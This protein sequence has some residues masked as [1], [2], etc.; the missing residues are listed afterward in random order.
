MNKRIFL[1]LI[2]FLLTGCYDH[3]ELNKIAILTATEINKVNDEYI[4]KAEVVNPQSAEKST[5][6][7]APFIIYTGKGKTIQEAYRQIKLQSSRY[8]YSDHLQIVIINEQI[9]KEDISEII[10]F[11]MRSPAA[12]TEFNVL[13]GADKDIL[14]ITTPIDELSSTSILESLK[15]NHKYLGVSN[16]VTFNDFVNMNLNPNMEIILPSIGISHNTNNKSS[17]KDNISNTES[18]EIETMFKMNGLSVFKNN[19]LLGYL[20]D[21]ESISYNIIKG[22]VENVIINY[23]CSKN[24][25][26]SMEIVTSSSKIT[27]KNQEININIKLNGNIK[28][29]SCDMELNTNKDIKK[30]EKQISK[31]L[32]KNIKKDINHIRNKYNSDIFGFLDIIYRHDYNTYNQIK[33]SWYQET[34]KKIKINVNTKIEISSTGNIMEANYD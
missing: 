23:E 16:L 24:K 26:L 13:I 18:T 2:I 15:T 33:N 6:T 30:A 25:Y 5:V 28:E 10:D 8:L 19:K 7:Q 4:V 31:Y 1:I 17:E 11:Y 20:T 3:S 14:S 27:T 34:F 32:N 29:L 12:R 22:N 21:N 9:A